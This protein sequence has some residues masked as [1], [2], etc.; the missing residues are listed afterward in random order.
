MK[1]QTQCQILLHRCIVGR[2]HM[3]GRPEKLLC[4]FPLSCTVSSVHW[5][6]IFPS[7]GQLDPLKR[8]LQALNFGSGSRSGSGLL[9]SVTRGSHAGGV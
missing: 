4:P 9:R 6:D 3:K 5:I 7:A 1:K 2:V 8:R